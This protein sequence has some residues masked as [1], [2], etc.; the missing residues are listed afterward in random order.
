LLHSKEISKQSF[1]D[2]ATKHAIENPKFLPHYLTL[3][4]FRENIECFNGFNTLYEL[5]WQIQEL[6]WNITKEMSNIRYTDTS[7]FY[8]SVRKAAEHHVDTAESIHSD[9]KQ[10]FKKRKNS[11]I[12]ALSHVAS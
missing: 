11:F 2:R 6:L 5:A 10:F 8:A 12:K 1:I 9:L 3:E 7:E 4:K